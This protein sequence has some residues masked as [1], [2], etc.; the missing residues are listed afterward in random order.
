MDDPRVLIS[1]D[2]WH[3]E[4]QGIVANF[5]IPVTLAPIDR[6]ESM[7]DQSFDLIVLAQ[8][9]AD[10]ISADA[11]ERIQ[12]K[13]PLTPIVALLGSWCEGGMRSDEPWLGVRRIYW[14][15]WL[16]RFEQFS[17]QLR[18]AG[19]AIWHQPKTASDADDTLFEC[20]DSNEPAPER[21]I[22]ISAADQ[23]QFE[24]LR[25]SFETFSWNSCWAERATF[26]EGTVEMV[27]AVC[28]DANSFSEDLQSRIDW[29]QS[30]L[31]TTPTA[32]TLNFPRSQDLNAAARRGIHEIVSKPFQLNDL[33]QAIDRAIKHQQDSVSQ[34]Q[35]ISTPHFSA[36][37]FRSQK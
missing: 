14:H 15:Q 29:L 11:V 33:K 34:Q 12:A 28:I 17:M 7:L 19:I 31:P 16:G 18:G 8:S 35:N 37:V 22:A 36:P 25:D 20:A 21:L 2:Y 32:L 3:H 6:L 9:R 1:G 27:S 23:T 13:Q 10:Q 30:K 24:F 4:F 5:S 26:D